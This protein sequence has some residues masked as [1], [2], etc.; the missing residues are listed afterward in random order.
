M[1]LYKCQHRKS[2]VSIYSRDHC[3]W[4]LVHAKEQAAAEIV[5]QVA[6][7]MIDV[8]HNTVYGGDIDS[9]ARVMQNM[10]QQIDVR[11]LNVSK[12]RAKQL[13]TNVNNVSLQIKVERY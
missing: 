11:T 3:R 6:A 13:V 2:N 5:E 4:Q 8:S 12:P 10:V 1:S 9:I 7:D